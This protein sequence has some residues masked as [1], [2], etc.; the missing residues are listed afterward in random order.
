VDA[1]QPAGVRER[2][3]R[4]ELCFGT[5]DTFLVWKL[6]GGGRHVTDVSN[7][8]RTLLFNIHTGAWD[9]ELLALLR[10]PRAVLPEVASSSEVYATVG[11]EIL[12]NGCRSPG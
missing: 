5:V 8:S 2:A 11:A 1:G 12:L 7:A 9:D 3:E 10:I 4:G 6:S